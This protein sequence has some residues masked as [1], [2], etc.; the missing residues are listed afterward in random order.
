[1][2]ARFA[3]AI[4][5]LSVISTAMYAQTELAGKW[6]TDPPAA[7]ADGAAGGG[8]RGAAT[9]P[10]PANLMVLGLDGKSPLPGASN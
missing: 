3:M 4:A 6:V 1:M 9:S 5:L 7:Q 10:R 8:G 2:K